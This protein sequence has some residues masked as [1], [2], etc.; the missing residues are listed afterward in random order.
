VTHGVREKVE[1]IASRREEAANAITHG[2]GLL[3]S[4][5]GT[6]ALI[7]AA[8][9]RDDTLAIVG[10]TI[11][12]ASL[13]LLYTVSTLYHIVAHR[14]AK[15]RLRLLD[16]VAIYLL[17]A[18]TYTPFTFGVLRGNWG[19]T[20]FG[21][22]WSLAVIGVL[23]KLRFRFRN[24]GASTLLYIAMGWVALIAIHPMVTSMQTPGV[25][26]LAAGGVLYTGGCIFYRQKRAWS[27]PVWH[28]FVLAGS[29][30]HYF[31][32]LLYSA[33]SRLPA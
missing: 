17:I 7:I 19:W 21:I 23:G 31:A 16:H 12:G 8:R 30:C 27:H 14:V 15:S 9:S 33:P 10:A 3:L 5:I 25:V 28:L 26:L 6:P 11:Y 2:L 29:A 4:I 1:R 24:D 22:V 13:I 18:G 32:V 20:M